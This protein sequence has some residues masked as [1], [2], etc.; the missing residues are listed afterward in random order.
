MDDVISNFIG[1][2]GAND[3]AARQL[4]EMCGG[5]LEQAIQLWFS[6]EELQRNLSNAGSS[7]LPTAPAASTST[8]ARPNRSIGREG[9]DGVIYID[10]DDDDQDQIMIDDDDEDAD[11]AAARAAAAAAQE[12]EDAAMAKRLQEELYNGQAPGEDG[13]RAPMARTTET[14]VAPTVG[15]DDDD[16]SMT[17]LEQMRQRR[18]MQARSRNPFGQ[19]IWEDPAGGSA[20]FPTAP[21]VPAPASQPSNRA[22]RLAE[23]FRPPYDLMQHISWDEARDQGKEDKKWILVNL[24]NMSDFNCQA[25]NRDL[26]KDEPIRELVKENFIFLQY[27]KDGGQGDQY[28][29]FYFPNGQHENPDNYPHVSI[30]DPRT[31]EQVKVWSGLPFPTPLEFHAQLVEFLD[32]YSL[33]AKSKNPVVK[34]KRAEKAVDVGRM[35]EEEMLEM[36]LKNSMETNGGSS[37]SNVHDPDELTK[38]IGDLAAGKGKEVDTGASTELSAFAKIASDRPHTEP[39]NNPATTTRIQFRHP[40][41][42]V[43][44]RF[45]LDDPVERIYEW[46]KA[47]PLEGKEGVEFELKV[48]PQGRDLIQELPKTLSEAGLKQA[49]VMIEF[50]QD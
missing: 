10:S 6:D 29:A 20:S 19:S 25:L 31:G 34:A 16:I 50:I 21:P 45:S 8:A 43:I 4:L 11:A 39:E 46:L 7:S 35:T 33:D 40:T 49:T 1:I 48:M 28:V 22:Q 9:S 18:Q 23:L 17:V 32:R 26:W 3:H 2:T 15:Y 47:E 41:G 44:R 30:V 13:V 12:D 42:R 27:D 37:K 38:S 24:Q 14:L 5:D 36:A